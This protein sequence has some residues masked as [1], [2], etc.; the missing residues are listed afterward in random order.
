MRISQIGDY[1]CVHLVTV[2]LFGDLNTSSNTEQNCLIF[3][4]AFQNLF[5]GMR[6]LFLFDFMEKSVR[7]FIPLLLLLLCLALFFILKTVG[8]KAKP[9]RN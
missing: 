2:R 7:D 9:T 1:Y 5:R 3:C 8:Q 4:S 6:S